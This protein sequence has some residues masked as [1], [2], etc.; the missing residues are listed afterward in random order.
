MIEASHHGGRLAEVPAEMDNFG[1]GI[2]G[3]QGIK[4][5]TASIGA[6][7]VHED[8][9]VG[10]SEA[11]HDLLDLGKESLDRAVLVIDRNGD[12]NHVGMQP[13]RKPEPPLQVK[14]GGTR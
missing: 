8:H 9:L 5:R 1:L 7:I 10:A 4:H 14:V 3:S 2:L 6:S 13:S 11:V 12:G